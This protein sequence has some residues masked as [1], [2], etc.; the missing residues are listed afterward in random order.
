MNNKNKKVRIISSFIRGDRIER[1]GKKG[2]TTGLVLG[3]LAK[4]TCA[5]MCTPQAEQGS[6][7]P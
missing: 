3:S 7:P 2:Q 5:P 4:A 1:N 6:P